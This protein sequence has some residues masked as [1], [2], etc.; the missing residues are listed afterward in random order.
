MWSLRG[1][2]SSG[3]GNACQ[4]CPRHQW[5]QIGR[6]AQGQ[7]QQNEVPVW[8]G[9]YPAPGGPGELSPEGELAALKRGVEALARDLDGIARRIDEL[10]RNSSDSPCRWMFKIGFWKGV[11]PQ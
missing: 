4:D 10:D 5:L 9:S 2:D 1:L 8:P 11:S 7:R 3:G 6:W